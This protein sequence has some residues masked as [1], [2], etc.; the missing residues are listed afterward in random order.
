MLENWPTG[1]LSATY[2]ARRERNYARNFF[3]GL[4]LTLTTPSASSNPNNMSLAKLNL[5][6]IEAL[7]RPTIPNSNH[8]ITKINHPTTNFLA[9]FTDS[10]KLIITSPT[11][12]TFLLTPATKR[13]KVFAI[14]FA[15]A[16]ACVFRR[17]S[18]FLASF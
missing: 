9:A 13:H 6:R 18:F 2:R 10:Q 4:I 12:Q 11:K 16:P 8:T 1:M 7:S 3:H 5:N 17:R 14:D 15:A